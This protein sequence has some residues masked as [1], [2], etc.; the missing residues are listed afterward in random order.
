[1][2]CSSVSLVSTLASSCSKALDQSE[3][4]TLLM[5]YLVL[6]MFSI[7]FSLWSIINLMALWSESRARSGST[8]QSLKVS[9]SVASGLVKDRSAFP[10]MAGKVGDFTSRVS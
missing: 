4:S 5:Q 7:S 2:S 3:G 8:A 10:C 6:K 9:R 1:M